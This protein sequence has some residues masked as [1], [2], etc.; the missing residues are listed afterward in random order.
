MENK[1]Q[2][3]KDF[4]TR[5]KGEYQAKYGFEM[6]EWTAIMLYE[7]TERFAVFHDIIGES[8]RGVDKATQQIKGQLTPIHFNNEKEAFKYGLGKTIGNAIA[9]AFTVCCVSCLAFGLIYTSQE[10]KDKR[11]F[12]DEYKNIEHYRLLSIGGNII[13]QGNG[14]YLVLK[15]KPNKGD[16]TIGT[17]YARGDKKN[18]ILVPLGR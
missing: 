6:D 2:V 10:Y 9:I 12:L 13:E 5:L 18:E 7:M 15:L 14:K 11:S 8:K 16:I 1:T 3:N 17:E 4:I